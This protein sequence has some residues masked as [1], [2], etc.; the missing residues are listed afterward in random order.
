M[1][2]EMTNEGVDVIWGLGDLGVRLFEGLINN[3][4]K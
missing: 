4:G 1:I 2:M 3:R